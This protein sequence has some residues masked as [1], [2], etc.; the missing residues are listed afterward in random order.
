MSYL[1]DE[2]MRLEGL[3]GVLADVAVDMGAAS[4]CEHD[5]LSSNMDT[6]AEAR[7]YGRATK[8]H[9][10]GEL[11]GTL[12]EVREQLSRVI[13]ESAGECYACHKRELD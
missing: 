10:R 5:V 8:M 6:A 1:K 12:Q 13:E 4:R 11:D 7:A 9:Q 2:M 3:R